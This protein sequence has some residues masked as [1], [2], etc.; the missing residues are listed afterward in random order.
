MRAR[1][2]QVSTP[3]P[4]FGVDFDASARAMHQS[5]LKG[6][7]MV[8][9]TA[10]STPAASRKSLGA[11]LFERNTM[12]KTLKRKIALVAVAGL[13]FGLVSTVPANAAVTAA[14]GVVAPSADGSSR[15]AVIAR[16]GG[17]GTPATE[18][19]AFLGQVV[20]LNLSLTDGDA[21]ENT[22]TIEVQSTANA[23]QTFTKVSGDALTQTDADTITMAGVARFTAAAATNDVEMGDAVATD[24]TITLLTAISGSITAANAGPLRANSG[25]TTNIMWSA[26]AG[27]IKPSA[28]A[29]M[30]LTTLA[31]PDAST[32]TYTP[33]TGALDLATAGGVSVGSVRV[34]VA[35]NYTLLSFWDMNANGTAESSEPQ[36]IYSFATSAAATQID[37]QAGQSAAANQAKEFSVALKTAA[38][39]LTQAVA[40]EFVSISAVATTGTVTLG[41]GAGSATTGNATTLVANTTGGAATAST[42]F[43]AFSDFADGYVNFTVAG[44]TAGDTITIT[45]TPSATLVSAGAAAKTTT[46]TTVAANASTAMKATVTTNSLLIA[47]AAN[48]TASLNAYTASVDVTTF[49]FNVTGLTANS[50]YTADITLSANAG[51]RTATLDGVAYAIANGA[52]TGAGNEGTDVVRTA[53]SSG[54]DT[55]TLVLSGGLANGETITLDLNAGVADAASQTDARVAVA[56]LSYTNT[57]STPAAFPS[58]S[59]AGSPIVLSGTVADQFSNPVGGV[60]VTATG[61]VTPAGTALTGTTVTG[62]DGKWTI[63]VTPA[64]ATTSVSFG[65]TAVRTGITIGALTT[66]VV[67]ITAGGSPTSGAATT[68]PAT[69][70]TTIPAIVVP[71]QGRAVAVSDESYTLATATAAGTLDGTGVDS[72]NESCIAL[73]PTTTPASN[74]VITGSAGVLFYSTVC[75]NAATHD[76]SAGKTTLTVASGTQIWAT[77]TKAGENTITMTSGTVATTAKFWAV[78]SIGIANRGLAARNIDVTGPASLDTAGISTVKVKVTDAFGNPVRITASTV[79]GAETAIIGVSITGSALLSGNATTVNVTS[80]DAAGEATVAIIGLSTAG[81]AVITAASTDITNAQFTSAAGAANSTTAGTNGLTAS[82][83][84]KALTVPV[85]ASAAVS[86]TDTEVAAVKADVKAVSDTVATLSKAVTTIQSSVTELTTS[87]TAQIKSLSSAIAKISRAIAALSKKIK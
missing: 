6:S 30:V 84:S 28:T 26:T 46:L 78:N 71:Y 10:F 18:I 62:N 40:N 23:A 37:V 65:V 64:A 55:L 41:N 54:A 61:A 48:T 85:K 29:P 14:S 7:L 12:L 57:I 27:G 20:N 13:G 2:N 53:N 81:D 34:N 35:G 42:A 17:A 80:T 44:N 36:V 21:G 8:H 32:V 86:K 76:V 38:G 74:I 51:T 25:Q 1:L 19:A 5:A 33:A 47:S 56:S 66:Q 45:V 15:Y 39:A 11:T 50:S 79:G 3:N 82:V 70:T 52:Q 69:T 9:E 68:N 22:S 24:A 31:S 75:A 60:T 49:V 16:T 72:A 59:I 83:A 63:T 43:I 58:I 77:S 73:T 4:E 87:F 67:N